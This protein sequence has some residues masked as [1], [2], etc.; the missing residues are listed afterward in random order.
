MHAR[1]ISDEKRWTQ[2]DYAQLDS[3]DGADPADPLAVRFCAVG[4]LRR[5][6]HELSSDNESFAVLTDRV[7]DGIESFAKTRGDLAGKFSLEDLNDGESGHADV[8]KLFDDYLAGSV[9]SDKPKNS[10]ATDW[11]AELTP[12]GSFIIQTG[13]T[14]PTADPA[15]ARPRSLRSPAACRRALYAKR[16]SRQPAF[17]GHRSSRASAAGAPFHAA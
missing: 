16:A 13:G 15:R 17:N 8:L 10:R 6:A 12:P 5:A 11:V 14:V 1:L 2:F 3:S 7:Q 4:A 9:R